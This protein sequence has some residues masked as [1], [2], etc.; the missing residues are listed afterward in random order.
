MLNG[1]GA[2]SESEGELTP[3]SAATYIADMLQGMSDVARRS[4]LASLAQLLDI[5][6]AE[7]RLAASDIAPDGAGANA[8]SH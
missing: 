3:A 5:V 2:A 6:H 8:S 4:G 1:G 7:A